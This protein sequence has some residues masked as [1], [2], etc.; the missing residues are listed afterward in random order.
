MTGIETYREVLEEK[1]AE[2]DALLSN[3][4]PIAVERHPDPLDDVF[5]YTQRENAAALTRPRR[6][7]REAV[8]AALDRIKTGDFGICEN[9]DE[10][11]PARRLDAVP[12]AA[13]CVA[14][15]NNR[16]VEEQEETD[17]ADLQQ[18]F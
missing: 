15:E 16:A 13:R 8:L 18:D 4:E 14:C 7:T 10:P 12:W 5:Q 11:I 17:D 6:A 1:L 2:L 9:C 3:R